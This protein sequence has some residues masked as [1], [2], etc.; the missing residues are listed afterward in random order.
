[1]TDQDT[2]TTSNRIIVGIDGSEPSKAALRWAARLAP[3]LG[4]TIHAVSA[5]QYPVLA[6]GGV[7]LLGGA[8]LPDYTVPFDAE[9]VMTDVLEATLREVFPAG[10]PDGLTTAVVHGQPG[11]VMLDACDGATMVIVG[12]RG[13]GG[14]S[15]LLLGSVSTAVSQHAKCPVLVVHGA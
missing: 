2:R 4:C 9:Q 13:H 3:T 7:G 1:M 15:G 14:F 11:A 6:D 8:V 5:W 12:S 10:R